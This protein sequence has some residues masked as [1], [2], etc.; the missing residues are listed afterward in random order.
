MAHLP[1]HPCHLA[2]L[3]DSQDSAVR[4]RQE[5]TDTD[6]GEDADADAEGKAIADADSHA[7]A[8]GKAIA[9]ADAEAGT[10]AVRIHCCKEKGTSPVQ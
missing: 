2:G 1:R 3:L 5:H 8:E 7:D 9:D 10:D 4:G 6:A